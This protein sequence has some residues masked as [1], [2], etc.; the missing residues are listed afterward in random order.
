MHTWIFVLCLCAASLFAQSDEIAFER[1]TTQQ[2]LS[3]GSVLSMVQDNRGFMWFGTEDGLNRWDGHSFKIFRANSR[4]TSSL[5]RSYVEALCVD[6]EGTL[7]VGT[8]GGLSRYNPYSESFQNY[9]TGDNQRGLTNGYITSIAEDS[10]RK[11]LWIGTYGGGLNRLTKATGEVVHYRKQAGQNNALQSD[12]IWRV[13]VTASGQVWV[14]SYDG[15]LYQYQPA[16]NNFLRFTPDSSLAQA[17]RVNDLQAI[18]SDRLGK[19]WIGTNRSGLWRVEYNPTTK[20]A[21]FT[22]FPH[23]P[24]NPASIASSKV[25]AVWETRNGNL[26]AATDNGFSMMNKTQGEFKTYRKERT[27]IESLVNDEVLSLY[28]D[29]DGTV[30]VGT[31]DGISFFNPQSR[32]FI[33]YRAQPNFPQGLSNNAV[34][35][36]AEDK[37]GKIW[38]GTEDGLNRMETRP[39]DG[40]SGIFSVWKANN[41]PKQLEENFI[42]T[43][44]VARDGTLWIGTDGSGV[45]ALRQTAV[46]GNASFEHYVAEEGDAASLTGNSVSKIIEDRDGKIWVATYGGVC[47]LESI[48]ASGKA[49]FTRFTYNKDVPAKSLSSPIVLAMC[50]DRAGLMWIGTENGLTRL[51][52]KTGDTKIYRSENGRPESL[53]DNAIQFI[54]EDKAGNLWLATEGG[55]NKFDREREKF[56]VVEVSVEGS[57]AKLLE[58]LKST[59]M[60]VQ[61]DKSGTL[62]LSTNHGLVRFVPQSGEMRLYEERDGLQGD[63]FITGAALTSKNGTMFF[64]GTNGFSVF[65]PDSLRKNSSKPRIAFTGFTSFGKLV[66]LD[67]VITEKRSIALAHNN[68]SFEIQFAALN[69]SFSSRTRYRY[70][71]EGFENTWHYAEAAQYDARYTN[72]D[73]GLYR[74]RVESRLYDGLW[75]DSGAMLDI[76]ILPPF[77]ATW[78]FRAALLSFCAAIAVIVVLNRSGRVSLAS[79]SAATLSV[80][81]ISELISELM[82]N[83]IM[84][85]LFP[86]NEGAE[87]ISALLIKVVIIYFALVP[88]EKR[89]H[90][91]F[92]GRKSP[93]EKQE[94]S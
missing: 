9:K 34:W 41:A 44:C 55:L 72:L 20:K 77:Y 46:F 13:H 10:S 74:F 29:R 63:E 66:P 38:V 65:H 85:S 31:R 42:S 81:L 50:Q 16:T 64:G 71:L 15:G 27:T 7:W 78:W 18:S 94:F 11:Y 82:L 93:E 67:T 51:D 70:K 47:R 8:K 56:S 37:N 80:L 91:Y 54:Y 12:I 75:V 58:V 60:R 92:A 33:S 1:L 49:Q 43:L 36:F 22:H 6:S 90:S 84:K 21:V 88:L 57:D 79:A 28:E 87:Q 4:D 45:Y 68:N 5:P 89:L 59:V 39:L 76:E 30:W 69:F 24:S 52:A 17:W 32:K 62:W 73:I 2:G 83:P 40:G 25:S 3:Q 23:N 48:D 14:G 19:I 53:S 86:R 26:F 61:E 35:A